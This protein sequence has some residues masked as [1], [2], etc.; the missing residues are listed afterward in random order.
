MKQKCT[1]R[2]RS[3]RNYFLH[4][5]LQL[6]VGL[7]NFMILAEQDLSSPCMFLVETGE[8]VLSDQLDIL[9]KNI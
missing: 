5:Q 1:A 7:P 3:R 8:I 6:Q 4:G 2:H 9:G